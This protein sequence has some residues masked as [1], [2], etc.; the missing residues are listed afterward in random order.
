MRSKALAFCVLIIGIP[1]FAKPKPVM[2]SAK[3]ISQ[4][5]G[6]YRNGVAVM[7]VGTM[8]AGVP[9]VRR[10]DIVVVQ[11]DKYR[12]TWSEIG[13]KFIVLPVNGTVSFYRDKNSFIVLDS[14][15][16]KHKFALIHAEEIAPK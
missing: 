6:A 4:D 14:E 5:I 11:T 8:L 1:A 12:L 15:G 13:R 2:E 16:K 7:P 3:V 10:S 9:I